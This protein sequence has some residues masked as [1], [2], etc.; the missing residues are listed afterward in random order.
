MEGFSV[1]MHVPSGASSAVWWCG[2]D[3]SYV[4][5]DV[6]QEWGSIELVADRWEERLEREGEEEGEGG[7]SREMGGGWGK[8]PRDSSW[9][10]TSC[11]PHRVTSG[12]SNVGGGRT[13]SYTHLTL[14]TRR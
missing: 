4:Q 3:E 12:R 2:L 9:I 8:K 10:L 13:V 1:L 11:Q 7:K 5:D 14:P 6:E